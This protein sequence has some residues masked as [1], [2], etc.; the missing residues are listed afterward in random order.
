MGVSRNYQEWLRLFVPSV[1]KVFTVLSVGHLFVQ[2][3]AILVFL[4]ILHAP[5]CLKILGH[6]R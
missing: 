5:R 1:E 2:I 4:S 6:A 3:V